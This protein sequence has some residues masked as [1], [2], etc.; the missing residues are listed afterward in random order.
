MTVQRRVSELSSSKDVFER[1]KGHYNEALIR[2]GYKGDIQY[3]PPTNKPK[4]RRRKVLW[5]NPSFCQSLKTKIGAEF[6]KLIDICFPKEHPL[7]KIINR[8]TV[9]VSPSCMSNVNTIISGINKKKLGQTQ[10]VSEDETCNCKQNPCPLEGKCNIKDIVYKAEIFNTPEKLFYLG[11]TARRFIERYHTHKGSLQHR[12]S[13]NHTSLSKKVWQ[14]R[15]QGL[16]PLVSFS[17]F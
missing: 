4:K 8:N 7:S 1:E 3:T 13:K 10:S 11:S 16:N 12:N 9:K 2:S 6:L 15:D 17:I 5:F 14:L